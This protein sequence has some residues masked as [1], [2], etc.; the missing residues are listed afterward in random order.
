MSY[1]WIVIVSVIKI[2]TLIDLIGVHL[3]TMT[4][5]IYIKTIFTKSNKYFD[6]KMLKCNRFKLKQISQYIIKKKW[7]L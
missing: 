1:I 3:Y 5:E 4:L 7:H 6:G 2:L